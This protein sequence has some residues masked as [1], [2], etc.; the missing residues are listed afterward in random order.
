VLTAVARNATRALKTAGAA[1]VNASDDGNDSAS[2]ASHSSR[3]EERSMNAQAGAGAAISVA[4]ALSVARSACAALTEVALCHADV[5]R[6]MYRGDDDDEGN[7]DDDQESESAIEQ[8]ESAAGNE[9]LGYL[10]EA[11]LGDALHGWAA[12]DA[13]MGACWFWS[14]CV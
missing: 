4:H 5:A 10:V 14:L 12:A 3:V 11:L 7:D 9:R 8:G 6:R 13:T 2:N 1:S